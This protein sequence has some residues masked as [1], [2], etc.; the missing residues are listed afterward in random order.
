[1]ERALDIPEIAGG[2]EGVWLQAGDLVGECGVSGGVLHRGGLDDVP[3]V[4]FGSAFQRG[5]QAGGGGHEVFAGRGDVRIE[6]GK[7]EEKQAHGRVQLAVVSSSRPFAMSDRQWAI[8]K[9]A[10]GSEDKRSTR[11]VQRS[12]F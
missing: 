2:G 4:T 10:V 3:V 9:V 6:S 7:L 1:M 5:A 8:G 11:N 12:S